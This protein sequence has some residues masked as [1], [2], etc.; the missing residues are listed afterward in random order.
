M[1]RSRRRPFCASAEVP[2]A[3]RISALSP[4]PAPTRSP[5]NAERFLPWNQGNDTFLL[6]RADMSVI[7]RIYPENGGRR[8]TRQRVDDRRCD[9][10]ETGYRAARMTRCAAAVVATSWPT[11]RG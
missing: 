8:Y 6:N 2:C 1:C 9:A 4:L 11:G 5:V 7:I 3:A 10:A